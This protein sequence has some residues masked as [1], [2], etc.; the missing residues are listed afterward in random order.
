MNIRNT[1]RYK[2]NPEL[3]KQFQADQGLVAD[4]KYGPKT[5]YALAELGVVPPRPRYWAS[6]TVKVDKPT[7]TRRMLAYAAT[8]P[9]RAADWTAASKVAND[10]VK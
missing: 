9:A 10:P 2:E 5:G 3:V 7:W 4:G 6:K 8:D 1:S